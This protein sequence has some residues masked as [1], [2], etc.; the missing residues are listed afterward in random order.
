MTKASWQEQTLQ[1]YY[2]DYLSEKNFKLI[3]KRFSSWQKKTLKEGRFSDAWVIDERLKP[4]NDKEDLIHHVLVVCFLAKHGEEF[5][6]NEK[7]RKDLKK[8]LKNTE[9]KKK[10]ADRLTK[11]LCIERESP[12]SVNHSILTARDS[13]D[14]DTKKLLAP[15]DENTANY[16][17]T[18]SF[19]ENILK[20][21]SNSLGQT[22]D[23]FLW[24]AKQD[25]I[26]LPQQRNLGALLYPKRPPSQA[27]KGNTPQNSLIY[28]LAFLFRH[29][30]KNRKGYWLPS[31][32][33][34]IIKTGYPCYELISDLANAVFYPA[35][36]AIDEEKE[37][38]PQKVQDRVLSLTKANVEL[39][40][41][42]GQNIPTKPNKGS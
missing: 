19:I 39:G 11:K 6:L 10:L 41:W 7:L 23:H 14:K 26:I 18:S 17:W 8:F 32:K 3:L 30:T 28:S 13:I 21:Y 38:T 40:C 1:K 33:G 16:L 12:I 34:T 27:Q 9:E 22:L 31:T 42:F 15:L 25:D 4:G 2:P 36:H 5:D 35:G 29:F 20:A 24:L 37:F